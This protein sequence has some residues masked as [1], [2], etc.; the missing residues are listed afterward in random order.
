MQAR[1]AI[2]RKQLRLDAEDIR[3][4][5][6]IGERCK[7][8][9]FYAQELDKEEEAVSELIKDTPLKYSWSKERERVFESQKCC[10]SQGDQQA[11]DLADAKEGRPVDDLGEERN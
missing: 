9:D 11:P 8:I 1:E 4:W 2:Q 5:A 6:E 7:R 3:F 10:K